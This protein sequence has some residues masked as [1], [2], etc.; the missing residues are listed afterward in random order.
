MR[1]RFSTVFFFT[2]SSRSLTNAVG[3]VLN[4]VSIIIY[5]YIYTY[6][7]T[8]ILYIIIYMYRYI[9]H[10]GRV[11]MCDNILCRCACLFYTKRIKKMRTNQ[12]RI[13]NGKI[14]HR[15]EKH[16]CA[17]TLPARNIKKTARSTDVQFI[18]RNVYNIYIRYTR[19]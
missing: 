10:V 14:Y 1:D 2:F 16:S 12:S 11:G 19:L 15:K 3:A 18:M 9:L 4:R 7:H 6:T 8:H 17:S 13:F 5:I